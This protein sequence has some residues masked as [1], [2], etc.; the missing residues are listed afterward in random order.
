MVMGWNFSKK[1][2]NFGRPDIQSDH[3]LVLNTISENSIMHW[4][5]FIAN[6]NTETGNVQS[7]MDILVAEWP[8]TA[9]IR[10]YR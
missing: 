1:H 3:I 9:V 10:T 2:E 6:S 4:S 8:Y 7:G 5:R